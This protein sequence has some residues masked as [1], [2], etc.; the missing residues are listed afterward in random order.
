MGIEWEYG[1]NHLGSPDFARR[2][3]EVYDFTIQE[4]MK[5]FN[6]AQ[7]W[8]NGDF[9]IFKSRVKTG[10]IIQPIGSMVLVYMLT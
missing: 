7:D 6:F 10:N 2:L 8:E 4:A 1:F 9:T 5:N 3:K